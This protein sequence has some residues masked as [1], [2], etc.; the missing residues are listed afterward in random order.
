MKHHESILVCGTGI[1]GLVFG[2]SMLGLNLVPVA[3]TLGLIAL[4]VV[5]TVAYV[6]HA[7]RTE[8]PVL[9][10]A[11]LEVLLTCSR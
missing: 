6:L 9:D 3:V 8:A 5:A 1:A 10:L 2:S 11:L 7:R 4:G